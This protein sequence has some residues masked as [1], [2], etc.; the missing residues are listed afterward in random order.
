[1]T[2]AERSERSD[3]AD[4]LCSQAFD[5]VD[6]PEA[7]VAL[8]AVGGYGRRELAPFSDLD[9]VLVHDD[10]VEL[11]EWAAQLWYPLW[12]SGANIDHSVRSV[13][14]MLEQASADL[15]VALGLLD[16]RHLAGDPNLTLRLRSAVLAAWRQGA[17][18]RLPDLGSLVV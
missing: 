7:G 16:L 9:L 14:E 13:G 6:C 8:V 5:R 10:D 1:M 18:A 3:A 11:G 2:A 12:D 15:R 4:A 17:R